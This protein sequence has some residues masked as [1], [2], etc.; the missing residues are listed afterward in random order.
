MKTLQAWIFMYPN[1]P[2]IKVGGV[3]SP[4][5]EMSKLRHRDIFKWSFYLSHVRKNILEALAKIFLKQDK[6]CINDNFKKK[7]PT[8]AY[9]VTK[10]K[11]SLEL[12]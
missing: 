5:L 6:L 2:L 12:S 7:Q 9:Y 4:I 11:C 10:A 8:F 1:D 3:I